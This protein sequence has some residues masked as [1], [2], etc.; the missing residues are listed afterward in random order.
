M[1]RYFITGTDTGVGKTF[2][3]TALARRARSLNPSWKVLAFKPIE[4]GCTGDLGEDQAALVAAAGDWQRDEARGVYQFRLPAAPFVAARAES[5]DI[6]LARI[7]RAL[8]SASNG[9]D[10]VLVEGAGG[11]RVPVTGSLDMAGMAR[12]LELP[13]LVVARGSLGTINHSLLTLEA[14]ERSGLAVAAL[15][16]SQHPDDDP[17]FTLSNAAEI[18]RQWPGTIIVFDGDQAQLDPLL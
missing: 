5:R 6:D 12:F 15:V 13:V 10:L 3:T 7:H 18:G 8:A 11:L 9:A 17:T 2:V 4:T 16:L 14:A 1:K